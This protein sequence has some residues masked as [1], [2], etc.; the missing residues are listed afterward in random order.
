MLRNIINVL[1]V[2]LFF[3]SLKIILS[4]IQLLIKKSGNISHS[5][6][7]FTAFNTKLRTRN[8]AAVYQEKYFHQKYSY[9]NELMSL[10]QVFNG[11]EYS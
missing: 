5:I 4:L 3:R 2:F 7:S 6:F 8:Y 10:M 9:H 11:T 1:F